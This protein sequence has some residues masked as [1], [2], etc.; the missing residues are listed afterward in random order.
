MKRLVLLG[1][2]HAHVHVLDALARARLPDTAVTLISPEPRQWYSGMLPGWIAG[3][4]RLEQCAID[5]VRL[6]QRAGC[7]FRQTHATGLDLDTRTVLCA[8][9]VPQ[10][11]DWLSIDVGPTTATEAIEGADA[12]ALA[13]RPIAS[14]VAAIEGILAGATEAP[15]APVAIVGAG[16][17]GVELAFA[18]RHR[19]PSTPIALIGTTPRPLDGLPGLLQLR[20]RHLMAERSIAWHGA[21]R[22]VAVDA[23]GVHLAS[24]ARIAASRVLQVT[25]AAAPAWPAAAGLATDARGFIRVTPTLQSISHPAVFA[26]GDVAAYA[27]PRPKSGVFAVRAGPPLAQNLRRAV[28]GQSLAPW[29]PQRRALYLLSTGDGHALGAWGPLG[30]WGDWVWRWKDRIDRRFMARF[31]A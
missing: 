28:L 27:E 12:H 25:G 24:G 26:A 23:N 4:Y 15:G 31:G 7:T 17:A 22:A 13:V 20:V 19:C 29:S 1:G 8:D 2:G 21:S 6:T 5:L 11:F 9:G 10:P 18:L 30:W 16:A 14:F 3:H